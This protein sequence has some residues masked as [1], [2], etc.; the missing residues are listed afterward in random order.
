LI[1]FLPDHASQIFFLLIWKSKITTS[2]NPLEKYFYQNRRNII[3][4]WTHYF[5]VY[6]WHFQKFVETECV[7]LEIGVSQGGSLQMWKNFFGENERTFWKAG[8]FAGL[9]LP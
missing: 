6:H 8:S 3:H 5:E 4:K 9:P 2:Q 7:V 1:A